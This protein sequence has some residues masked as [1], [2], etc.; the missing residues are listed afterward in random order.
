MGLTR[1]PGLR[2]VPGIEKLQ[3][4]CRDPRCEAV[5]RSDRNSRRGPPVSRANL[6]RRR[7][8][9]TVSDAGRAVQPAGRARS[10]GEPLVQPSL[11]SGCRELL[12][13]TNGRKPD[14]SNGC[15]SYG[16]VSG[17]ALLRPG[18]SQPSL[19]V[20]L[21]ERHP[22]RGSEPGA[23]KSVELSL[24]IA[25]APG[26]R[27]LPHAPRRRWRGPIDARRAR[28]RAHECRARSDRP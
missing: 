5:R 13:G 16:R 4:F 25:W 6:D 18:R 2:R 3:R 7:G 28:R 27:R 9:S 10:A 19:A 26:S 14:L 22:L 23:G 24:F 17:I 21:P 15:V 20:R 1:Q 8:R 11:V 12:G